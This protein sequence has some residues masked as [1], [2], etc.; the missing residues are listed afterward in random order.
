[1]PEQASLK[2]SAPTAT[3][4]L[5]LWIKVCTQP[6]QSPFGDSGSLWSACHTLLL[7]KLGHWPSFFRM[8]NQFSHS[9]VERG[10]IP[11]EAQPGPGLAPKPCRLANGRQAFFC[12]RVGSPGRCLCA[13]VYSQTRGIRLIQW[14]L[15]H[16]SGNHQSGPH[17]LLLASL[18][19]LRAWGCPIRGTGEGAWLHGSC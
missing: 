18:T 14:P 5:W 10:P 9:R 7:K 16:C 11:A 15:F 13:R 17:P 8:E 4:S 1:M 12:L 6:E 19:A 3:T 2:P